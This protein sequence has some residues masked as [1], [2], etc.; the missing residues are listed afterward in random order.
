MHLKKT[1][2]PIIRELNCCV[3]SEEWLSRSGEAGSNGTDKKQRKN[4]DSVIKPSDF[5][6]NLGPG[7]YVEAG[8]ILGEIKGRVA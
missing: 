3:L 6:T 8:I 1:T 5:A 2:P 7:P 4:K